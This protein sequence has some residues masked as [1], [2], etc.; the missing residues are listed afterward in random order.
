MHLVQLSLLG[1][2]LPQ[3]GKRLLLIIFIGV[4][5]PKLISILSRNNKP[6]PSH[7]VHPGTIE[8]ARYCKTSGKGIGWND[9]AISVVGVNSAG[10]RGTVVIGADEGA[11]VIVTGMG[12]FVTVGE[13]LGGELQD[14]TKTLD[15]PI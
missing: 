8:N 2:S 12:V 10:T 6:Y 3:I 9:L 4:E 5:Y 14:P 15:N 11:G 7:P 13:V 1:I